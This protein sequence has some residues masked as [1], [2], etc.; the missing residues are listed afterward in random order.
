MWCPNQKS[1]DGYEMQ[2]ATNHLGHFLLTNL[3]LDRLVKSAPS[4]IIVVS[5]IAHN[6]KYMY[7]WSATS[8]DIRIAV[9]VHV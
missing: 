5:S 8:F 9:C 6:R 2:L 4:R 3:L 7:T 1:E